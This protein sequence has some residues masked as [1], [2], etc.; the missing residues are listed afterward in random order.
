MG[1]MK[2]KM[3]EIQEYL[4]NGYD[5][6]DTATILDIPIEWV[7]EALKKLDV[8]YNHSEIGTFE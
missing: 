4:E 6:E 1:G 2:N 8:E 5:V 7:K 3:A